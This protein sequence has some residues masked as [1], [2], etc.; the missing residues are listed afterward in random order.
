MA[1]PNYITDFPN[2]PDLDQ[3]VNNPQKLIDF[4][5][6][7]LIFVELE[8][9]PLMQESL[10]F[11]RLSE[12]GFQ[13]DTNERNPLD[14]INQAQNELEIL[15]GKDFYKHPAFIAIQNKIGVIV[16]SALNE[17]VFIKLPE[18]QTGEV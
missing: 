8:N 2:R 7:G 6:D 12:L 10:G 16:D 11:T 14:P 4:L 5:Y 1:F 13:N 9:D 17:V 18:N 15:L 3:Y